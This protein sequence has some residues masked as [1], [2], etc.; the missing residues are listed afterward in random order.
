MI[1]VRI[2]GGLG[3]QMFQYA[4]GRRLAAIHGAVLKLDISD[5][6]N[7]TL[8]DYGLSAF[9]IKEAIATQEEI[10]LFKE[11]ETSSLKKKIKKLLGYPNK[12]GITHIRESQYHFDPAILTMHDSVYLDGYW[13][14]EKYF[15]DISVIIRNEFTATSPQ[16]GR[17]L[18]LAQH[19]AS[20]ESISLHVR[21]GDYVTDEKTNTIHGTCDLDYYV[22]CIE[23]VAQKVRRPCFFIFSDDPEWA[24]KNLHITHQ[25]TFISHNGPKKNY[26][27]LRLM[28]QCRHHI[29]ANSSFS[30]WGAWLGQH[31]DTIVYAPKRW[32]NSPLFNT[33]DLLPET[34][35]RI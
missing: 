5:F 26:E 24:E 4:A 1:I 18:A 12:L 25:A 19:M 32:F 6:T 31:Q 27:D 10:R 2:M 17:N 21:R 16:T 33:Q 8:H 30:W 20:C 15:S 22:R 35:T 23:R 29:I 14:S 9:N 28:S 13:Q 3:N 7:Y 11:P 34:W